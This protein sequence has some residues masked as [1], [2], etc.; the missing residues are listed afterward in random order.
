MSYWLCHE[1]VIK[2]ERQGEILHLHNMGQ[3]GWFI[4][5]TF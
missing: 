2:H 4:V 3:I 1:Q 5:F